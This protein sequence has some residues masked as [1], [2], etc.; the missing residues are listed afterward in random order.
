VWGRGLTSDGCASSRHMRRNREPF[1]VLLFP[2]IGVA[3]VRLPTICTPTGSPSGA[4][5]VGISSSNANPRCASW[6]RQGSPC[7]Q[8]H[9]MKSA[10][11]GDPRLPRRANDGA[12]TMISPT[13]APDQLL[14]VRVPPSKLSPANDRFQP[15]ELTLQSEFPP[16][17]REPSTAAR[18]C[19]AAQG[20]VGA[21][22]HPMSISNRR[23]DACD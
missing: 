14:R 13:A 4:K 5:P 8:R 11:P 17:P 18:V 10:A 12:G 7:G 16:T 3:P 21:C 20:R 23:S 19:V 9:A 15:Q 1:P 22:E 6:F 2:A